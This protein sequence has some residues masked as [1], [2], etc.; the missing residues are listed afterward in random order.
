MGMRGW[1]G[2]LTTK[3]YWWDGVY[4]DEGCVKDRLLLSGVLITACWP[5]LG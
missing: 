1:S 4:K 2:D 5:E 3:D